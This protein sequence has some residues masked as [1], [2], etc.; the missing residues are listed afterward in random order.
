MKEALHPS[1][2]IDPALS[3]IIRE[4]SA[5]AEQL[6]MLHPKQLSVIYA[7]KW[8]NLFV[9]TAYNGLGL[10]L[11][12]GLKIE[13]GLAWADGST[14]WTVTLCSGANW[15]IGFLHPEMVKNIFNNHK[16]C[17]AG[18]GYPSGIAKIISQGYEITGC[19]KYATGAPH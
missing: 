13:E 6:G 1:S 16:P 4:A 8:F 17:L 10:L 15:F 18:S 19:W 5:E 11:P 2:F 14:G 12:E 9:P 3:T 7:Q